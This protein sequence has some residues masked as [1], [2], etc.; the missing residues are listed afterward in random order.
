MDNLEFTHK[1]KRM[2]LNA[3]LSESSRP[4]AT[5]SSRMKN[6]ADHLKEYLKKM[7]IEDFFEYPQGISLSQYKDFNKGEGETRL[8]W[9]EKLSRY[10]GTISTQKGLINFIT[11]K[12]FDVKS[13]IYVYSTDITNDEGE[14]SQLLMFSN[15]KGP[16]EEDFF[17]KIEKIVDKA[18]ELAI[19]E[20]YQVLNPR[21][22]ELGDS[23]E[24]EK[25]DFIEKEMISAIEEDQFSENN[26]KTGSL[27]FAKWITTI[28]MLI[29][30]L[31]FID[32]DPNTDNLTPSSW[33]VL[34]V[35]FLGWVYLITEGLKKW[36]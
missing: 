4:F 22:E 18:Y 26:Y 28:I 11:T 16:S 36:L 7:L 31:F 12:Q 13:P 14:T 15:I 33:L 32:V 21:D 8:A 20:R 27:V 2:I 29:L 35:L 10:T 6:K 1:I 34:S 25:V 5:N 17:L 19:F 3:A 9:V 23:D 30:F 24:N